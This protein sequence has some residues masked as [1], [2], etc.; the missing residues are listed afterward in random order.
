M[1]KKKKP[2]KSLVE[3]HT[4]KLPHKVLFY[5][6]KLSGETA[7]YLENNVAILEEE[8]LEGSSKRGD[9]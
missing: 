6:K 9:D 8:Q 5:V 2:Q 7:P 1:K 4:Q 3:S